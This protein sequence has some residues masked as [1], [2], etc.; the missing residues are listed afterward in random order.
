M[1]PL[2]AFRSLAEPYAVT[3]WFVLFQTE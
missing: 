3:Q 1:E 2:G